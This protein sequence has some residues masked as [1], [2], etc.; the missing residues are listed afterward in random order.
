[1]EPNLITFTFMSRSDANYLQNPQLGFTRSKQ[2]SL[3]IL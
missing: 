1:M 3:P 2:I